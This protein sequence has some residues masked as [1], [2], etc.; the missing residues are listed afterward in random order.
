MRNEWDGYISSSSFRVLN[1]PHYLFTHMSSPLEAT[2]TWCMNKDYTLELVLLASFCR[3]Q[4]QHPG[5]AQ[6]LQILT[7]WFLQLILPFGA[8]QALD[9]LLEHTQ[10]ALCCGLA[11]FAA[12]CLLEK[13]SF[14]FAS[15][16]Q[17]SC[18]ERCPPGSHGAQCE[19]RCPC[20]NGGICHHITGECSCPAG[21]MVCNKCPVA[22]RVDLG[23][24]VRWKVCADMLTW[25]CLCCH[26]CLLSLV[27]HNCMYVWHFGAGTPSFCYVQAHNITHDGG[28]LVP[29]QYKQKNN[30]WPACSMCA[31]VAG[32]ASVCG[33]WKIRKGT[34]ADKAR[35]RESSRSGR[36]LESTYPLVRVWG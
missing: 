16:L 31:L 36:G 13:C 27:I 24:G 32:T 35:S 3:T 14:A 33:M 15:S 25:L 2:E 22:T 11:S 6:M 17:H 5:E 23:G 21:W 26:T 19:L 1:L 4:T 10:D 7:N 8:P 9:D 29:W 30:R 28:P 34:V 20:Q 18:E 12:S